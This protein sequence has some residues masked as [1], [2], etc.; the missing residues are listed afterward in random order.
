MKLFLKLFYETVSVQLTMLHN[1]SLNVDILWAGR[2]FMKL[3]SFCTKGRNRQVNISW[4]FKEFMKL[5]IFCNKGSFSL[6][7][8]QYC[9]VIHCNSPPGII[10]TFVRLQFGYFAILPSTDSACHCS[11]YRRRVR[12]SQSSL[13]IWHFQFDFFSGTTSC[14][15]CWNTANSE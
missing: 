4:A 10:L 13:I 3:F 11:V 9:P 15:H 8:S 14:C 12:A 6:D 1:S 5:L 2:E 7:F